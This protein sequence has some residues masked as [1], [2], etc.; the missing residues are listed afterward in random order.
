MGVNMV[1]VK[2]TSYSDLVNMAPGDGVTDGVGVVGGFG[3]VTD[4]VT[5]GVDGVVGGLVDTVGG[6]NVDV[7]TDGV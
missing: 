5:D 1:D 7:I 6:V 4:G 2:R 3:V